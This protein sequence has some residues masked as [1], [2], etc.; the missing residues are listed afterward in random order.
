LIEDLKNLSANISIFELLKFPL[1]LQKMIQNIAENS[2]NDDL[3][4]KKN[5]EVNSKIAQKIPTKTTYK[6]LEKRDLTEKT[7]SNVDE[8]VSG[9]TT[10]NQQNS[11]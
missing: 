7:V 6:P 4:N 5:T 11:C 9:T 3:N 1:I 2:R 10:K 8:I